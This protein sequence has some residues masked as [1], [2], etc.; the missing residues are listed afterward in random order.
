MLHVSTGKKVRT[1]TR[2]GCEQGGS[3]S[4]A[5]LGESTVGA[6]EAFKEKDVFDKVLLYGRESWG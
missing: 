5:D 1:Q 3:P 2:L 4:D 6:G